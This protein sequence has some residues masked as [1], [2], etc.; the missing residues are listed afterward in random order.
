MLSDCL[1]TNSAASNNE[2]CCFQNFQTCS[3]LRRSK[4]W[5]DTGHNTTGAAQ[6]LLKLTFYLEKTTYFRRVPS[7]SKH[8]RSTRKYWK[9]VDIFVLQYS[10]VLISKNLSK[11][12]NETL[13]GCK[14]FGNCFSETFIYRV[15]FHKHFACSSGVLLIAC[16]FQESK[17]NACEKIH[18]K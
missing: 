4:G 10:C 11:D 5:W 9:L 18:D 13:D 2:K 12:Q 1:F 6:T 8:D 17:Q 3:N 14:R 15:F 7:C 16:K